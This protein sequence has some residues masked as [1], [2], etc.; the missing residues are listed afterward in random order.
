[1]FVLAGNF[2]SKVAACG[3]AADYPALRDGFAS[4]AALIERHDKIKVVGGACGF[5]HQRL[6]CFAYCCCVGSGLQSGRALSA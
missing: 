1:M 5:V 2:T 3:G 6:G 4:L